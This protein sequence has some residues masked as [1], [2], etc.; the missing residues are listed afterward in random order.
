MTVRECV[1]ANRLIMKIE[2]QPGYAEYI[3]LSYKMVGA[4]NYDGAD[5]KLVKNRIKEK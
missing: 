2:S 4:K 1:I 3:G 5:K